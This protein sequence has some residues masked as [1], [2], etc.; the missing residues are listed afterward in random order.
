M[1]REPGPFKRAILIYNP[2]A[3][4]LQHRRAAK[5]RQ[6]EEALSAAGIAVEIMATERSLHAAQL[7]RGARPD[8]CLRR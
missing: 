2:V 4:R 8:H 6:I 5:L 7:A 1:D 3:R